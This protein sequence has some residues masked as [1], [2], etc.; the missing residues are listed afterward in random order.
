MRNT[1][2]FEV[3]VAS[4]FPNKFTYSQILSTV[5]F[6]TVIG[7]KAEERQLKMGITRQSIAAESTLSNS[8]I[9]I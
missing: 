1:D 5:N 7:T 9:I 3:F 6:M 8:Q 4:V 2:A